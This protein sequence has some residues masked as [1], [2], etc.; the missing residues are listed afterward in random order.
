MR[1]VRISTRCP[2]ARRRGPMRACTPPALPSQR[3]GCASTSGHC[4]LGGEAHRRRSTRRCAAAWMGPSTCLVS[5]DHP[6]N[7]RSRGDF[8]PGEVYVLV[9]AFRLHGT[10]A[11]M[12]LTLQDTRACCDRTRVCSAE[13]RGLRPGSCLSTGD[14]GSGPSGLWC[15]PGAGRRDRALPGDCVACGRHGRGRQHSVGR[16]PGRRRRWCCSPRSSR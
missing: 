15:L 9:I 6:R 8:L 4:R 7:H 2:T 13:C 5:V 3:R 1:T 14:G 12:L 11:G 10:V 16:G